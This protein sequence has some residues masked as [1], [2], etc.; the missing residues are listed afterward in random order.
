MQKIYDILRQLP[1]FTG[2]SLQRLSELINTIKFHFQKYTPEETII[3]HGQPIDRLR[4]IISGTVRETTVNADGRLRVSMLI[5]A[6]DVLLPQ[7]FFG[8][9]TASPC[10]I[11]AEGPAATMELT[12]QEYMKVLASDEVF[13]YNYLNILSLSAQKGVDGVLSISH[14]SLEERIAYW[15]VMLTAPRAHD[16]VINCRLRDLY[17]LYGVQRSA[18]IGALDRMVEQGLLTYT[19]DSISF[20]DRAALVR[21]LAHEE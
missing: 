19:R 18:F 8:R 10:L 7:F 4:F 5:D 14:G 21:L 12:K 2:A 6:P 20:T 15:V 3:H 11:T 16:V 9:N 1:L 17:G 13:L